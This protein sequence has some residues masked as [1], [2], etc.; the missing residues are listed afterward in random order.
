MAPNVPMGNELCSRATAIQL[1]SSSF[2]HCFDFISIVVDFTAIEGF[3]F[4]MKILCLMRNYSNESVVSPI[5]RGGRFIGRVVR[6][7][8]PIQALILLLLGAASLIPYGE[9]DY[10]CTAANNFARSLEPMLQYPDGPPP[11]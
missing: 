3:L 4:L 6:A 2:K 8:L 7:S 9:Q 11:I 1:V 5:I 10:S